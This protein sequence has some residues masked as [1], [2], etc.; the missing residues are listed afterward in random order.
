[1]L[2]MFVAPAAATATTD[3]RV[4]IHGTMTF[5]HPMALGVDVVDLDTGTPLQM[6]RAVNVQEGWV[7]VYK[8]DRKGRIKLK[9]PGKIVRW[10]ERDGKQFPVYQRGW[11]E[12]VVEHLYGRYEV[13]RKLQYA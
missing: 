4:D 10:E 7:E 5:D 3:R 2:A 8:T 1:M 9:A 6:V 11:D 13:W 12:P